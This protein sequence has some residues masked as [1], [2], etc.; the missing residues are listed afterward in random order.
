MGNNLREGVCN[1]SQLQGK[2]SITA[3]KAWQQKPERAG[4]LLPQASLEA[5]RFWKQ[6][7]AIKAQSPPTVTNFLQ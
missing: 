5:E 1:G 7:Q 6:G 3:K 2:Q 4:P